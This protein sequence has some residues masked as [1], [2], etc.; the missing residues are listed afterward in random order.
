MKYDDAS[1][2]SGGDFPAD[3]PPEAG[4]THAGMFF[5]WAVLAGLGSADMAA[6][7]ARETNDLRA[8]HLT[9]GHFFLVVC[10]GKLTDADLSEEGNN[11]AQAYFDDGDFL[12]DYEGLVGRGLPSIYHVADSWETYDKL[13]PR[14]DQRFSAW[15]AGRA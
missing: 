8:K 4:A 3:L 14:I 12:A 1:W 11:F 9:P 10:D 15:K 6:D 7:F 2:H 5:A 13:K